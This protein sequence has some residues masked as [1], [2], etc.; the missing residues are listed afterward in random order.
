MMTAFFKA[1]V[2]A[3]SFV[4]CLYLV[5]NVTGS[6]GLAVLCGVV[7]VIFMVMISMENESD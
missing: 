2:A 3:M 7:H 6:T 5:F 1:L 4:G